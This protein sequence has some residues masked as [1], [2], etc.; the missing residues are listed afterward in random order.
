[1]LSA[2]YILQSFKS[3]FQVR[4]YIIKKK[5][6]FNFFPCDCFFIPTHHRY[7]PDGIDIYFDN[8]GAEMLEAAVAKA[9]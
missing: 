6:G 3:A 1:M 9:R 7:I 2:L 8:V 4:L 5:K